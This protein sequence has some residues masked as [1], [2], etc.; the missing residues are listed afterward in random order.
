V[1]EILCEWTETGDIRTKYRQ[2]PAELF[3]DCSNGVDR[4]LRGI[5]EQ[6]L[7]DFMRRIER[8]PVILMSLRLLD[9]WARYDPKIKA[10]HIPT[11]PYATA[12]LKILGDLLRDRI[13]ET[14]SILYD[15][16][17]KAEQLVE[18][19]QE[20]Y[21]EI[22]NSLKE[23]DR[24]Q[25]PVGRLAEA[26]TSLQGRANTQVNLIKLLDS[27]LL[28]DRPNGLA[29]KRT[30]M[31]NAGPDVPRKRSDLRALVFS[32]S[33]L[34]YLV[35]LHVLPSGNKHGSRPL[36]L[37]E[38]LRRLHERY[39]F[40]IDVSPPG[41][42]VSN[43]VL[44][45]NRATLERRLRDLGLLVGVNDAEAMKRLRPRFEPAGEHEDGLD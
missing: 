45:A 44:Q 17:Q 14:K 43:E 16:T 13:P 25:S 32:D 8:F 1:V 26:L 10:M 18:K 4:R 11:K 35:H 7:E 27:C 29:S 21:P 5:A 38:F 19:L 37:K 40:C 3:V 6:S 42:T 9:R 20:D 24:E 31:R 15:L 2:R 30:V 36:S 34:D 22:A 39:G 33:V 12:W 28:V 41:L 23:S